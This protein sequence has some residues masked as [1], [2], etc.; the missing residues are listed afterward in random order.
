M[1]EEFLKPGMIGTIIAQSG[2]SEIDPLTSIAQH[3]M[4]EHVIWRCNYSLWLKHCVVIT[5]LD[6]KDDSIVDSCKR[7]QTLAYRCDLDSSSIRYDAISWYEKSHG[8]VEYVVAIEPDWPLIDPIVMDTLIERTYFGGFDGGIMSGYP[9]GTDVQIARTRLKSIPSGVYHTL[10]SGRACGMI[11]LDTD[12]CQ[13]VYIL[14]RSK[15]ISFMDW[16]VSD[17]TDLLFVRCIYHYCHHPTKG[18]VF[19]IE[20]VLNLLDHVPHLKEMQRK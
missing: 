6:K 17:P 4:L 7:T 16:R 14:K 3:A 15:D 13:P 9:K 1:S 8:P 19:F 18:G 11:V 2:E 5:S 20:D 12:K 10:V